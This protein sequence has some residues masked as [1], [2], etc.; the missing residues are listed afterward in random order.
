MLGELNNVILLLDIGLNDLMG[1]IGLFSRLDRA[2]I[3]FGGSS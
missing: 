1:E 3:N 2:I